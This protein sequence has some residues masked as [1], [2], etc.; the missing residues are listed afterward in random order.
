MLHN[1]EWVYPPSSNMESINSWP[2]SDINEVLELGHS[3]L[4]SFIFVSDGVTAW[5]GRYENASGTYKELGEIVDKQKI[6]AEQLQQSLSGKVWAGRHLTNSDRDDKK[7]QSELVQSDEYPQY[8]GI[9]VILTFG[10]DNY[11]FEWTYWTDPS[12]DDMLVEIIFRDDRP[13]QQSIE[14]RTKYIDYAQLPNG[15]WY[16]THWQTTITEL[17][18]GDSRQ[19]ATLDYHLQ[20]YPDILLDDWWFTT[21]INNLKAQN[22]TVR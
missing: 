6:I 18:N 5:Q 12:R 11:R 16:P 3:T 14:D 17:S 13:G 9:N 8:V 1:K 4:P 7:I 19:I 22:P 2:L 10:Y 20:I 21:L 15:Q